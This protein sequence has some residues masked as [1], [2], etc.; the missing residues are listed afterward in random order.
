MRQQVNDIL[1]AEEKAA[2]EDDL[3]QFFA[4]TET[5]TTV[6]YYKSGTLSFN[7]ETG[8]VTDTG[9]TTVSSKKA[10]KVRPRQDEM[11]DMHTE[12]AS[13]VWLMK[14]SDLSSVTPAIDDYILVG[15]VKKYIKFISKP[16]PGIHYRFWTADEGNN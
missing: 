6:S 11:E 12:K 7:S 5:V 1:T 2:L 8:A 3:D 9:G 10:F 14:A 4:D 15:S 13:E 16:T